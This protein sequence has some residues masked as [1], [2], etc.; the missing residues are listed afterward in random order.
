M[1]E[2]RFCKSPL[3]FVFADLG[4]T[5][6]AN[7]Y[8]SKDDLGKPEVWYPLKAYVCDECLLVQ[9]DDMATPAQIFSD[10]AYF[11]SQSPTWVAAAKQCA[12]KMIDSLQLKYNSKVIEVGSND[13]YLLQHFKAAGIPVHGVDPASNIAEY[14]NEQGIPTTCGFFGVELANRLVDF[15]HRADLLCGTNV[16]AHVP[17]LNDF[18]AGLALLIKPDGVI[19]MEFPHLMNTISRNQWD[20]I[21]HEHFSYFSLFTIQKVFAKHGLEIFN[22]DQL[23]THG[24]SIR[25]YA[26]RVGLRP[27]NPSVKNVLLCEKEDG[28]HD[29]HGYEGF[30]YTFNKTKRCLL[31]TL[32]TLKSGGKRIC[33]YGAPAKGNTLLNACGIDRDTIPITVDD[34]PHKQGLFLPGSHIPIVSRDIMNMMQPDYV[35]ILPWNL[36][37][38]IIQAN[39]Q[40]RN[41]GGKWM[42]AIP[43]LTTF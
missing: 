23:E 42:V 7:S 13:G 30:R 22:V 32:N 38:T 25:I 34:S 5:P 3:S 35:L 27:I 2:C 26:G 20:T 39:P 19:T 41:N 28:L 15:G 24:G 33:A 16:L 9:I 36:A 8:L 6:L 31:E 11:S 43:E 17:D 12:L 14:A 4:H 40:V 21:Y 37:D 10:Y 29:I 1:K 18:V